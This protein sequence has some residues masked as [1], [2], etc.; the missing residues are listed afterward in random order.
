LHLLQAG[1]AHDAR[2]TAGVSHA[3]VDASWM[4][5]T[6]A[7]SHGHARQSSLLAHYKRYVPALILDRLRSEGRPDG[8]SQERMDCAVL[9]AD[10]S[11]FT[12]LTEAFTR[13]GSGGAESLTHVLNDYFGRLIETVQ[14]HAGDIVKFAGDAM[15][16]LW[17]AEDGPDALHRAT[18]RAAACGLEM[19]RAVTG[20]IAEGGHPLS[21]KVAVG[22]GSLA[23]VHI[24]GEFNRWEFAIAGEPMHQV[25]HAG[26]LAEPGDVLVSAQAWTLIER[27]ATSPGQR[28]SA[29]DGVY[30]LEAIDG[31]F[32]PLAPP[33]HDVPA[34]LEEAVRGYLP[35]AITRRIMA[36]QT[37]Y[38]SELRN[39]T[40]LFVN[41]PDIRYDTALEVAQQAMRSLQKALYFPFEGSIN[42][43]SVDDK[44]VTLIAALG[45]P[46]FSHEDD[47]ARGALAG[48]AMHRVLDQLG[49]RCSVGVTTGRVYCGSVGSAVRQEYTI[50]GDKVNL[51]ARLMQN[52][53][54]GIL[55]DADTFE[56]SV[57]QVDYDDGREIKVKGKAAPVQVYVPRDGKRREERHSR[58]G[59]SEMIGR[60]PELARMRTALDAL[61]QQGRNGAVVIEGEAGIGKS[62]L[63]EAFAVTAAEAPVRRL[64]GAADAIERT[65]S[66]LAWQDI[67]LQL[68]SL[69]EI[70]P[71][72]RG[73]HIARLLADDAAAAPMLPLL[74]SVLQ[75][76]LP[77]TPLTRE[78]RGE[79]RANNLHQLIV[80]LLS[81][82]AARQ[83][84]LVIIEDVHWLDS[85]SWSLLSAVTQAVSPL[86]VVLLTRPQGAATP[87]ELR[88][89][90]AAASCT[91]IQLERMA[92]EETVQL[93]AR[94]L[95]VR[96]LPEPV[97]MLIRDR[98]EGHPFFA[99]EIGYALRDGGQ[100]IV[101]NDE[102]RLRDQR[103]LDLA[104]VPATIEGIIT[105]RI[106][107]LQP[108]EQLTVKV[109]SVIGRVFQYGLLHDV[110]PVQADRESLPTHLNAL[111]QLDLTPLEAVNPEP[112]YIF[113]HIIT[114]QVAYDLML[115]EQRTDLHE[116]IATWH[117]SRHAQELT[118]YY[119]LLAHHWREAGEPSKAI[120][121]LELAA[122]R[123]VTANA[124]A[125]A[126]AFLDQIESQLRLHPELHIAA[127]H[128]AHLLTLRGKA[129][130]S[131]GR[132]EDAKHAFLEGLD[133]L[134]EPFPRRTAGIARGVLANLLKQVW[135]RRVRAPMPPAS[136]DERRRLVLASDLSEQLFLIYFFDNDVGH[137]LLST[138]CAINLSERSGDVSQG[139]IRGYMSLAVALQVV[140]LSNIADSYKARALRVLEQQDNRAIRAWSYVALSVLAAGKAH[141]D[142][143]ERR[144]EAAI[145]IYRQLGDHRGWEEAAGN[146]QLIQTLYGRWDEPEVA[147]YTQ[148]LESGRRRGSLQVQGWGHSLHAVAMHHRQREH[149]L[150]DALE[151]Y[152][153]FMRREPDF[154]DEITRLEGIGLLAQLR[155]RQG[156][157]DEARAFVDE[158][159][160]VIAALGMPSQ[161]RNMP[162]AQMLTEG[163]I[164]LAR[165]LPADMDLRTWR[166]EALA[167]VGKCARPYAIA[168]PKHA[169]L[170][171]KLAW[172]AGD[173]A[174][175]RRLWQAS[176]SDARSLRMPYDELLVQAARALLLED[177]DA[178]HE[179]ALLEARL[180]IGTPYEVRVMLA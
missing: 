105:S 81:Y 32:V 41:L 120:D 147:L 49:L 28:G 29:R 126:L 116:K 74:N 138:L 132:L 90:L 43:L 124:N 15:T 125:E 61:C 69:A 158:G 128:R 46:P 108:A 50:M 165:R 12:P 1:F 164:E 179:A 70:A 8:P 26:D 7:E 51:A 38:L 114:Q 100:L 104:D 31:V 145:E 150:E 134:G 65:T 176:L 72:E 36:G 71:A 18:L 166:D 44:G 4:S 22:A 11:G 63:L 25:G 84:L 62:R 172:Y 152:L 27:Q 76:E 135:H 167:F 159:R 133:V 30:R 94:R 118:L 88:L 52:A 160:R 163:A 13:E 23:V 137:I 148:L 14:S 9:F 154:R 5:G 139:L 40:I 140:P 35:A 144:S 122:E 73:A 102:C 96:S 117:E 101:E 180:G 123:A 171:G 110:Y 6:M 82:S 86:L 119:P 175:A 56:R 57:D 33:R 21:L 48:L 109:A 97:A 16:V 3:G 37:D 20:Y 39:L 59:A 68:L 75:L 141:W 10:I 19:Q 77:E 153:E 161:Y 168:R 106:D 53:M 67:L 42:K 60:R 91:H 129:L 143:A 2:G 89:L 103:A 93:V 78:M 162:A 47:P 80:R 149:A 98:A 174:G 169:W 87:A 151:T 17:R 107:R 92:P 146:Y 173:A 127:L 170:R 85:A 58:G 83:P 156:R 131:F 136:P 66:Y 34:E 121:Y 95:R 130:K 178:R 64:R 142:E 112:S 54:G 113:K 79:V 115:R 55:V 157:L 155:V 99:E 45:L 111:Q 24:G 177:P